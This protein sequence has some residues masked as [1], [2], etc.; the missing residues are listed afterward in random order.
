MMPV[1]VKMIRAVLKCRLLEGDEGLRPARGR[2]LRM[3]KV[4]NP[5]AKKFGSVLD[6]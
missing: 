2:S 5:K 3:A 4:V 1:T 6:A